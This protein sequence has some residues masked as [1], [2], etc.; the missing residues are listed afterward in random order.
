MPESS[1]TDTPPTD[2]VL[3]LVGR[4]LGIR[5]SQGQRGARAA[6]ATA[7]VPATEALAFPYT[8]SVLAPVRNP[9]QKAAAR[10]VAGMIATHKHTVQFQP[11]EDGPRHR[12]FGRSVELLHRRNFGYAPGDLDGSGSIKRNAITMQV[13]SLPL[14]PL[15]EAAQVIALLVSRCGDQGISVDFFDIARTLTYWGDG[16]S[17]RSRATRNRV[18]EDFYGAPSS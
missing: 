5:M 14:L 17:P 16:I 13:D 9:Q 3:T 6:L 15:E 1:T 18:V 10:R 8:E 12:P 7:L 4:A 11:A 2:P